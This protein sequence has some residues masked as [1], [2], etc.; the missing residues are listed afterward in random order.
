MAPSLRGVT[1]LFPVGSMLDMVH[2]LNLPCVAGVTVRTSLAAGLMMAGRYSGS[3]TCMLCVMTAAV[4]T[5]HPVTRQGLLFRAF[6]GLFTPFT[7]ALRIA[8]DLGSHPQGPIPIES[9][10]L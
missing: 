1:G 5:Y 8:T 4:R 6:R 10:R 9:C 2:W 3:G 7:N